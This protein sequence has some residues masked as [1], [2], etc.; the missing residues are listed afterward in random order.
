MRVSK[1]KKISFSNEEAVHRFSDTVYRVALDITK[2]D[3]DAQ[4]VVQEVFMRYIKYGEK[5]RFD[6]MEHSRAWFIRVTINCCRDLFAKQAKRSEIEMKDYEVEKLPF[7]K[8]LNNHA[9][10][11]DAVEELGEKY[12]LAIHLYYYEGY[13]TVEIAEILAENENT[14]K[15][16]LKRAKVMLEKKLQKNYDRE[17]TEDVATIPARKK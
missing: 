13:K 9:T 8:K 16:R 1:Q 6:S 5:K 17:V 11:L 10:V 14:I 7:N 12:R 4:D 2:N 3:F 15:T